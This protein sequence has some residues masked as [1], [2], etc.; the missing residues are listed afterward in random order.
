[1]IK[2]TQNITQNS[3]QNWYVEE[4]K[5]L[6]FRGKGKYHGSKDKKVIR[7]LNKSAKVCNLTTLQPCHFNAA[8]NCKS[9]L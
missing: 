5:T 8:G 2:Y 1:M 4:C 9:S 3:A 6:Q 7:D